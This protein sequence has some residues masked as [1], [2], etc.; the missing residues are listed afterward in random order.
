M[1]SAVDRSE[2]QP[3]Y[4]LLLSPLARTTPTDKGG[5]R[6][7]V[8]RCLVP[9]F[10]GFRVLGLGFLVFGFLGFGFLFFGFW[11][12]ILGFGFWV[13]GF[14]FWVLGLGFRV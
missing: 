11:F 6:V 2:Q 4:S 8:F 7:S 12:W 10:D 14:G 3:C 9:A 1:L 13:L 5:L